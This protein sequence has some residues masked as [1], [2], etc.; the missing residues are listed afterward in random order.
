M[1]ATPASSALAATTPR[2][3][4][5]AQRPEACRLEL[6]LDQAHLE[7]KAAAGAVTFLFR[8][9]YEPRWQRGLSALAREELVHFERTLKLLERRDRGF[10]RQ[11]QSGYAAGLKQ[12]I[13]SDMPGRLVDELLVAA[14]IEARSCERMDLLAQEL[15]DVDREL[16]DFYADLVAAEA[17]HEQLYREIAAELAG[18]EVA[19]ARWSELAAHEARVIAALPFAPRLHSGP[20]ANELTP[21][22]VTDGR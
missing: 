15:G 14:L 7:K 9:P 16:A 3:W 1:T 18:A 21:E 20:A 5:T 10:A 19:A 22:E 4:A 13:A 11:Q 17:R 12:G 2:A 6:L 8:V